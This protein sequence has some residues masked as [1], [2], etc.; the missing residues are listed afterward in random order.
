MAAHF[1]ARIQIIESAA[2]ASASKDDFIDQL[3][4][5][6]LY[7]AQKLKSVCLTMGQY[8]IQAG[9]GVR[10]RCIDA[11]WTHFSA[12]QVNPTQALNTTRKCTS[13][14]TWLLLVAVATIC[15]VALFVNDSID[16]QEASA[17]DLER[18]VQQQAPPVY[19]ALVCDT[20]E[21]VLH[22]RAVQTVQ[23]AHAA[24]D[25][26]NST[27]G[28]EKTL[29]QVAHVDTSS[30]WVN[31]AMLT[32]IVAYVVLTCAYQVCQCI[33]NMMHTTQIMHRNAVFEEVNA[34]ESGI[35]NAATTPHADVPTLPTKH[36]SARVALEALLCDSNEPSACASPHTEASDDSIVTHVSFDG[37]SVFDLTDLPALADLQDSKHGSPVFT[38]KP[39]FDE[40]S[41]YRKLAM[42]AASW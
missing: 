28:A 9:Q 27:M 7:N 18:F 29:D 23:T 10:D 31:V 42:R 12:E 38:R 37:I 1:H 15:A 33:H 36:E 14:P 8:P 13:L 34:I 5:N 20:A 22:M 6:D 26:V 41:D 21:A 30:V 24:I 32:A 11:L 19:R 25:P 39:W 16:V 17:R 40:M 35:A 4:V 3:K 2:R